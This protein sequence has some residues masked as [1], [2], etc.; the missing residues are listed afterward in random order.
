MQRPFP[1]SPFRREGQITKEPKVDLI[2][3][4]GKEVERND[5]KIL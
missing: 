3:Y 1:L 4:Q 2:K 5:V